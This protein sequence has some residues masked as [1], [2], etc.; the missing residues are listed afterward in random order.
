MTVL[1]PFF[2]EAPGK[3]L[4]VRGNPRADAPPRPADYPF[5]IAGDSFIPSA[6]PVLTPGTAV[7]VAV[8]GYNFGVSASPAPLDVRAEVVASDGKS[9][10]ASVKV[11]KRSDIERGGGRKVVM[12]FLPQGLAAGR[13]VLKVALTDPSSKTTAEAASPFEVK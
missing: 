13:Y 11:I 1:P 3:W 5:A 2:E 7:P 10:P 6:L 4:M 8:V 9:Q 12:D